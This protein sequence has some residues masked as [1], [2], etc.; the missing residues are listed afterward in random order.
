MNGGVD[1]GFDGETRRNRLARGWLEIESAGGRNPA[2]TTG[3]NSNSEFGE[4]T[5][6]FF[7][8]ALL[9]EIVPQLFLTWLMLYSVH[10][11]NI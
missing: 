2:R 8:F 10:S 11:C 5:R 1:L 4:E 9:A 7:Q 6:F 3:V